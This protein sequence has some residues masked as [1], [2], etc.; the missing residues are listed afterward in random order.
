MF[1]L[2]SRGASEELAKRIMSRT[3]CDLGR[4]QERVNIWTIVNNCESNIGDYLRTTMQ[5]AAWTLTDCWE[6]SLEIS[7]TSTQRRREQQRKKGYIAPKSLHSYACSCMCWSDVVR[8]IRF[9]SHSSELE[10]LFAEVVKAQIGGT[11]LRPWGSRLLSSAV[12]CEAAPERAVMQLTP[13]SFNLFLPS[14]AIRVAPA[15][16][17]NKIKTYNIPMASQAMPSNFS[18]KRP[19]RSFAK[20]R[21][22]SALDWRFRKT[23][24][25]NSKTWNDRRSD[26]SAPYHSVPELMHC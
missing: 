8:C 16:Q 24:G 6:P 23:C 12:A 2:R 26:A 13:D 19:L 25:V 4:R 17:N 20:P 14:S 1:V 9:I 15:L 5:R 21:I 10:F 11:A 7:V 18:W 22:F 3:L